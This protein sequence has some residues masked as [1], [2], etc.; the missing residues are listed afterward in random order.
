MF[1]L[2]PWHQTDVLMNTADD[3]NFEGT[4]GLEHIWNIIWSELREIKVWN[5]TKCNVKKNSSCNL[6]FHQKHQMKWK[7]PLISLH[8]QVQA[9]NAAVKM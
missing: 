5:K 4:D 9:T 6:E 2:L 3:A 8:E 7:Y 1:L